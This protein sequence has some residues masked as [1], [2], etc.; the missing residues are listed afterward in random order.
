M[1]GVQPSRGGRRARAALLPL[2]LLL[3]PSAMGWA[4]GR[5]LPAPTRSRVASC[6]RTGFPQLQVAPALSRDAPAPTGPDPYKLVRED[7]DYIKASIKKTLNDNKG[8]SAITANEVL[9]MAARE[10]TQRKGKSFRPMLVLLIGRATD[11]DGGAALG[12]RHYKLAVIAEMIHTASLIHADVLEEDATDPSQGTPPLP[13]RAA[14]PPPPIAPHRPARRAGTMVHQEV[15]FDVGNK[16]CILA[17]DFLLSRASVELSLLDNADIT[18]IVAQASHR[19]PL[20]PPADPCGQFLSLRP[21]DLTARPLIPGPRGDLRGRHARV[22]GGDGP[23]GAESHARIVPS[24]HRARHR[25]ADRQHV[26]VLGH[27]LGPLAR[28][29]DQQGLHGLWRGGAPRSRRQWP[30]IDGGASSPLVARSLRLASAPHLG[31]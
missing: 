4:P 13:R 20:P 5:L 2:L 18:E 8:G 7:L 17:G 23:G 16:V 26:P 28:L 3:L 30:E 15:D 25:E 27:P 12:T 11:A 6:P 19:C 22:R 10:F 9:T 14:P 21:L 31:G 24:S 29:A 1:G